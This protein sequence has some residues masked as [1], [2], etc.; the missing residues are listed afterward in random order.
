M[1]KLKDIQEFKEYLSSGRWAEDFDFRTQ[2]GQD[3]MLDLIE[4][5]FEL[6][7]VADEI[8]TKKLYQR[9]SGKGIEPSGNSSLK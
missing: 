5:L 2:D 1:L 8:L 4:N 3:E 6:C 7:E 9:M